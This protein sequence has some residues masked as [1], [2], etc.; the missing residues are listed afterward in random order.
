ML[1]LRGAL[2]SALVAI[3][4]TQLAIPIRAV[5]LLAGTVMVMEGIVNV[6]NA[7]DGVKARQGRWG[8]FLSI[9][10]GVLA[11]WFRSITAAQ[12]LYYVACWALATG[13]IEIGVAVW[14]GE[15]LG[16]RFWSVFAGLAT[17]AF[18]LSLLLQMG[19]PLRTAL[20]LLAA[21]GVPFVMILFTLALGAYACMKLIEAQSTAL[22]P[23]R[24]RLR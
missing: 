7:T 13:M 6:L 23:V 5:S 9:A 22:S 21:C 20:A 17:L 15:P 19:D 10:M 3:I 14:R 8:G 4:F 16:S 24:P 2:W 1:L 11:F 18:G 12:L